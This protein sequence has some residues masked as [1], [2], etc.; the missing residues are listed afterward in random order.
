[1]RILDIYPPNEYPHLLAAP[2]PF[3]GAAPSIFLLLKTI[4]RTSVISWKKNNK[5]IFG[6]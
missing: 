4:N 1:M 3:K 2:F 5:E 6:I